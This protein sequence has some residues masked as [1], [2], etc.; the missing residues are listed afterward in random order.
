MLKIAANPRKFARVFLRVLDKEKNLVPFAWN[1]AQ[2]H[3]HEHQTGRDLIL[4]AR[5][6]G[7][8]TL[9]QGEM[10]RKTVTSTQTTITLAHDADTTQKLRRMADRFY[11]N[12]KFGETQPL[13]KYANATLATYP[14]FDSTSTI[15]TAGN[16]E[17][18]RGDTY[19][20]MHGSEVA[21]WKDAER[22]VAG[23][24]QGGSPDVILESTPNGAQGFFYDK[25]MEALGGGSIWT[26]HFYPWW[27][28]DGYRVIDDEQIT[29]TAEENALIT[30]H[31]LDSAQIK[32][33]RSKIRELGRLFIQEYPEDV[34]SCFL[35]S[36]NSYF[37]DLAGVFTAPAG[38][39]YIEGH[40][41][42]AG[43]DFGQ[44]DY[45]AMPVFDKTTREQVDLLHINKTEWSEQ[46]NRIKAMYD[47]WHLRGVLAEKNSIGAVNID[48]LRSIGVYA[49][50]FET[51]NESKASIM[52]NM[53]EL[54]HSGW[55]LLDIP[56]QKH[57]FNTFVSSQL[58]S[59][60]WRLAAEGN[61][62]D[63]IVMACGIGLWS[64][65]IPSPD[66]LIDFA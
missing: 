60:A 40:E 45:T 36:G 29:Y 39:V 14:E 26:L 27:W 4:K 23:A 17:T 66:M 53:H 54:L 65:R 13:R 7:F 12:C 38:A 51:T 22:I 49:T 62:H 43:L 15:A 47:K 16:V 34:I 6:M 35:T 50:P 11:E 32:W 58:P 19:T 33:R 52:S 3:F 21:F 37:G 2:Q 41:Y 28:D 61:G 18:G 56:V 64:I 46:R 8:S 25:C 24:M 55:K 57:E 9:I 1:K 59:G 30:K 44:T 10:F 31:E 48:A 63:D 42:I 5:Q 20:M